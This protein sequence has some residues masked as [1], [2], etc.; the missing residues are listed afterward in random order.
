MR[1][2]FE[3][4][5]AVGAAGSPGEEM[6]KQ[7]GLG[8]KT[9]WPQGVADHYSATSTDGPLTSRSALCQE[10]MVTKDL[11]PPTGMRHKN[12]PSYTVENEAERRV[13][14]LFCFLTGHK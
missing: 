1:L 10:G 9:L 6:T 5:L 2:A 12:K 14:A 3:I 11:W 7:K 8:D 4:G 13:L